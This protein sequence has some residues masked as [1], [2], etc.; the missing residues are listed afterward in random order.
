MIR[1]LRA[2][3]SAAAL[4][5][6]SSAIFGAGDSVGPGPAAVVAPGS[7]AVRTS[8]TSSATRRPPGSSA[9]RCSGTCRWAA[10]ACRRA[11][12]ATSGPA[13]TPGRRTRSARAC[14]GSCSSRTP[15]ASRPRSRT[16]TSTSTARGRTTRSGSEDFPFR[17]LANPR[18]RESGD[19]R[20]T[21]TTWCPRRACTTRSSDR[22]AGPAPDPDGFRVGQG[23]RAAN[24]RRVEPRNTPT[25]INAGL[26]PP[27]LLGHAGPEPVQR[28]EP[29]R[30]PR[31]RRVPLQRRE[32]PEPPEGAGSPRELEPRLAGGRSADE[33]VRDVGGRADVPRRRPEPHAGAGTASSRHRPAPP[34]QPAARAPARRPRRQRARPATAA[35][36]CGA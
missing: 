9:R 14:S 21:R 27:Q 10:T 13:R 23:R 20:S 16:P 29:V 11:P 34:G 19:R 35:R 7:P 22:M 5:L 30:R 1:R 18:D 8:P 4:L 36:R 2:R 6:S 24:V 28:R 25:M 32:P 15:P 26:Q 33:P 3:L 17:R 31:P 12:P